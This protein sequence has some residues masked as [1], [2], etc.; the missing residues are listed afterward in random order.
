VRGCYRV[1]VCR[2]LIELRYIAQGIGRPHPGFEYVDD[3]LR[4]LLG[5]DAHGYRQSD[6]AQILYT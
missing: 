6:A 1:V 3:A 4:T 2:T 5:I